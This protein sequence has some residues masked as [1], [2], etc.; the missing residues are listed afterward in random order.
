MN[1]NWIKK[2]T[3]HLLDHPKNEIE[4]IADAIRKYTTFTSAHGS[5]FVP[6]CVPPIFNLTLSEAYAEVLRWRIVADTVGGDAIIVEE[7]EYK[8]ET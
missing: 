1:W 5:N 2:F 4:V 8:N 6:D 3:H 7:S